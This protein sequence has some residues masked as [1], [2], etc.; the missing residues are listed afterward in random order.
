LVW[1]NGRGWRGCLTGRN[2]WGR[3]KLTLA[4]RPDVTSRPRRTRREA[5]LDAAP[6]EGEESNTVANSADY[7]EHDVA[8]WKHRRRR[9]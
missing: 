3:L 2:R 1:S 5:V 9:D 6:A 8:G 4:R 7:R